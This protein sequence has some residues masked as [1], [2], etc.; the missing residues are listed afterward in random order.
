LDYVVRS[1]VTARKV[2]RGQD[3]GDV[4]ITSCYKSDWQLVPRTDEH[5]YLNVTKKPLPLNYVPDSISFPPLLNHFITMERQQK[6]ES[7]EERPVLPLR[8][9]VQ[10][11]RKVLSP[12]EE[13]STA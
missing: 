2:F 7:L 10:R 4:K 13:S 3:L 11:R 9:V 8:S 5:K 6:G 1:S 12:A